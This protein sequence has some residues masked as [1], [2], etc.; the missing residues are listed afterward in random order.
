MTPVSKIKLLAATAALIAL[1][2]MPVSALAGSRDGGGLGGAVGGVAGAVSGAVGGVSNAVGGVVGGATDAVG[3][4]V[5]GAT[6]A[7]GGVVGG[8]TSGVGGALGSPGIANTQKS[9]T[10]KNKA[11]AIL[12]VEL[13]KAKIGVYVL[14]KKGHLVRVDVKIATRALKANAH[15]YV[16]GKN[17]A[18][19]KV[20]AKVALAGLKAKTKVYV[21]DQNGML[22]GAN[23]RAMLGGPNGLKAKIGAN[24]GTSGVNVNLGLSVGGN[25]G[26]PGG[27]GGPGTPGGPGSQT[28]IAG[29]ISA[30]SPGERREL[31]KKCG[32]VLASPSSYDRDAVLVCRVLAQ[33]TGL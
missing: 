18:L 30:M 2:G 7:V 20:S 31:K 24:A 27:P 6:D 8:A 4:V 3:G 14:D 28:S 21:L 16:L 17:G 22:L 25:N 32:A 33:L 10:S 29:K 26:G 1:A 9:T 15:A 11:L 23:A 13:L 19:V 12:K 5:G